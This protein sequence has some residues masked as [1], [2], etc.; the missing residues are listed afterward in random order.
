MS[1]CWKASRSACVISVFA[2]ASIALLTSAVT[3]TVSQSCPGVMSRY[4]TG[5]HR[6]LRAVVL[7]KTKPY[8][9]N[10]E[11]DGGRSPRSSSRRAR[12]ASR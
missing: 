9:E 12:A 8:W 4:Q 5:L 2:Q 3:L 11:P 6:F 1:M 10:C 7:V